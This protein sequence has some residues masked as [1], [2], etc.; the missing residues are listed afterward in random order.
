MILWRA[1]MFIEGAKETMDGIRL[2]RLIKELQNFKVEVGYNE[3]SGSYPA[4][5][6]DES[7]TL[8]NVAAWN[9]FGSERSPAR[10]FMKQTVRDYKDQITKHANKA[11]KKAING[12]GAKE[13]LNSIGAYTKGR[14]QKE[15]R[16]GDFAPNAPYTIAKKGSDKPLI[17]TGRMRQNI[18]YVIKEKGT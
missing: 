2:K 15:I 16:D 11:L 8:A 3:D 14:M 1:D 7:I 12:G 5:E 9:E 17:D 13:A 18:V 10:P 4:E 6:G